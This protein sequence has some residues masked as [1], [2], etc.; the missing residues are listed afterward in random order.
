MEKLIIDENKLKPFKSGLEAELFLYEYNNETLIV[1]KYPNNA[2]LNT[3]I[4]KALELGKYN[5][6]NI[7][8]PKYIGIINDSE[9]CIIMDYKEN[10]IESN[11]IKTIFTLEEKIEHLRKLY[12][13]LKDFY[14]N[15]I[16]Y[17]DLNPKN[18][19]INEEEICLCDVLNFKKGDDFDESRFNLFAIYYLNN[20]IKY[21]NNLKRDVI[22]YLEEAINDFFNKKNEVK[23]IG[24]TDNLECIDIAY[25]LI[26]EEQIYDNILNHLEV[27]NMKIK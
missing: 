2:D 3:I 24:V 14:K 12:K 20:R 21:S 8:T 10:Y 22:P 26:K 25:K 6:E 7:T 15:G 13:I 9:N 23:L 5:I 16:I 27:E 1:K 4:D 18:I 19:L 11:N 17:L